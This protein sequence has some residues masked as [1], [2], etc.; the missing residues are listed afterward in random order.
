MPDHPHI[1]DELRG[2]DILPAKRGP[3]A[4][5]VEVRAAD[6]RDDPSVWE[7]EQ[8]MYEERAKKNERKSLST[9]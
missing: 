8:A 2:V 4:R 9:G 5:E 6:A 3:A 7:S 1:A